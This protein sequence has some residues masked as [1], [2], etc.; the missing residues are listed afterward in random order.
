MSQPSE[1]LSECIKVS[2]GDYAFQK[3]QTKLLQPNNGGETNVEI[4]KQMNDYISS[5]IQAQN[6]AGNNQLSSPENL[7]KMKHWQELQ[8]VLNQQLNHHKKE[9]SKHSEE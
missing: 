7:L 4:L 2:M 9:E 8:N 5:F 1:V 3:P 6:Q